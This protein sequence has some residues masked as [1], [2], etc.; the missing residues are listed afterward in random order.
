MPYEPSAMSQGLG[1]LAFIVACAVV[2][3]VWDKITGKGK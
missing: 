1:L 2:M 3:W